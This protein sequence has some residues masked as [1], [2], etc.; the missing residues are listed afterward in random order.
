MKYLLILGAFLLLTACQ[1]AQQNISPSAT[2]VLAPAGPFEGVD[3]QSLSAKDRQTLLEAS[4]D[5]QAVLSGKSPIHASEDSNADAPADGGTSFYVGKRYKLTVFKSISSFGSISGYVY[6][7]KIVFDDDFSPGNV[8]YV[9]SL[10]FYT[11][12]QLKLLLGS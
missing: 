10:R 11:S 12:Q 2:A 3:L 8:S 1:N 6:G 4:E 7:P 5:F 9:T